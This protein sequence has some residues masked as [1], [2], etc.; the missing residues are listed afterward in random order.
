MSARDEIEKLKR[1]FISLNTEEEKKD[2]DLKFRN[3]IASKSNEEK[4]KF[5]DAFTNS[6]KEDAKRIKNFCNEVTIR[7][8]LEEISNV[9]SMS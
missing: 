7:M 1:E 4:K 9:V 8:K 2:F 6:A 3:H 5:A